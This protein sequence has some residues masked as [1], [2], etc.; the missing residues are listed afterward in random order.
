MLANLLFTL[1]M[2]MGVSAWVSMPREQDPTINFNWIDITT[3]FPG[4]STT[5]VEQQ[6]TDILEEAIRSIADIRFVASTSREGISNVLVRFEEIDTRTF[7]KRVTDL[8]REIQNKKR[9]LPG[10][11]FDPIVTEITTANAFPTATVVVTGLENDEN[12]RR[13]AALIKQDLKQLRGVGTVLASGL[14]QPEL[15]I[16]FDPYA[17][18]SAGIS[19][20]TLANTVRSYYRGLAAGTIQVQDTNWSIKVNSLK[21]RIE[22]LRELPVLGS[23]EEIQLATLAEIRRGKEKSRRLVQLNGMPAVMFSINKQENQNIMQLVER[24]RHYIDERSM[25][26]RQTGVN[27]TLVD[28]QTQITRDALRIMQNNALIG[29]FMVLIVTWLFVGSR[30]A[31]LTGIA[32]PFI[33]AGTLWCLS[34]FGHTLNV[35]I[36]LGVVISLGMLV[37]DAVVVVEAIYYRLLRGIDTMP[38]TFGALRE[39]AAP[40]TTAVLTTMAAFLPLMLLPGILGQFMRVIP[41][42]VTIALAISLVEAFW[43]LPA[44]IISMR[45]N[46]SQPG[47]LQQLRTQLQRRLRIKYTRTL[48]RVMR[49]PFIALMLLIGLFAGALTV[50]LTERIKI[51]FFASDPIRLFYVS[52]QMPPGTEL[53]QTMAK[54]AEVEG[55]VRSYLIAEETRSVVSYSGQLFTEI[56]PLFGDQFGQI[57]VSLQ[58]KERALRSVASVIESMRE[59]I[60]STPGVSKITFLK[61]AGGPPTTKAISVK[62][63]GNDI[64]EIRQ[65]VQE[66]KDHLAGHDEYV[67]ISDDDLAGQQ[68]LKLNLNSDAIR[69]SGIHPDIVTQSVR[70]LVD[71]EVVNDFR[72]RGETIDVRVRSKYQSLHDIGELL[73]F[74]LPDQNGN[75]IPLERLVEYSISRSAANIKHYNYRRAITLEADIDKTMTDTVKANNSIKEHWRT[76]RNRYP[77]IDLDFTGT[78][79]DIEESIN[80]IGILFL[81]GLGLMYLILGTQFKSYFQPFLIIATVP[82]AFTGVVIGL[83]ITQNPLSLFTLYGVVALAG[84]AVNAAIVLISTANNRLEQGMTVTHA[85]I[86]A[87]RRRVIPIL[88]T[89]TTTIAGLFSLATGLGGHSLLWGPIATSI[90]WGLSVSTLLT[91]F[92]VPLLYR[93]F[94]RRGR[95]RMDEAS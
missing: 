58:P 23:M 27:V 26:S 52:L 50:V 25:V 80:A 70:L 2:V 33:L 61:L 21:N 37:D 88:I 7:E 31:F 66:L 29:L 69:R 72:H 15:Q 81:L 4:A 67:D 53:D 17:L 74:R 3:V 68:T 86:Y 49:H 87:A 18:E 46:F 28:D 45:I 30:I 6:V 20:V 57:L 51:D 34:A 93:T 56:E 13:Q 79:D 24:I 35:S 84:I 9:E 44:H 85:T 43:L 62:V 40:V 82:M 94:M 42:V 48:I 12:L 77:G 64:D 1:V 32:I 75:L 47:K 54:V 63:R 95:V 8:R 89:S 39:V 65:A 83:L 16:D 55:T 71:G 19:P 90:V 41:L 36:L 76:I 73:R 5:D 10:A 11:A 59:K 78:L 22:A 60:E 14:D 38:A 92:L 91:L